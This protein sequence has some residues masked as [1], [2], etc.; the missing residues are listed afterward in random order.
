[1]NP[2]MAA[3]DG[4]PHV[5]S[6]GVHNY[7][8]FDA[9]SCIHCGHTRPEEPADL[10]EAYE[11][12]QDGQGAE[13]EE[14]EAWPGQKLHHSQYAAMVEE[15]ARTGMYRD[16]VT[17]KMFPQGLHMKREPSREERRRLKKWRATGKVVGAFSKARS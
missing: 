9:Q 16:P 13:R 7:G 11:R 3:G 4:C 5:G 17:G 2:S 10:D 8:R 12:L 15:H 14:P 1:V 6:M